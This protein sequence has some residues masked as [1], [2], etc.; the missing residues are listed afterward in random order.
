MSGFEL[1]TA[2]TTLVPDSP[3]V[4]RQKTQSGYNSTGNSTGYNSGADSGDDLFEGVITTPPAKHYTQSTQL[5]DRTPAAKQFSRHTEVIDLTPIAT[6]A[7]QPTQII[8]RAPAETHFTQ[9]T[10]IIDRTAPLS[11]PGNITSPEVQ[12]PVSSPFRP[13]PISSV[14]NVSYAPK[15]GRLAS[16]MAPAGTSFRAPYSTVDPRPAK[17]LIVIDLSD[18]DGPQYK[19]GSSDDDSPLRGEIKPSNFLPKSKKFSLTGSEANGSSPTGSESSGQSRFHDI[20]TNSKF[21]PIK[22]SAGA[23]LTGSVFDSRNRDPRSTSSH[24]VTPAVKK[25]SDSTSMG[26]GSQRRQQAQSQPERAM[27]VPQ[28]ISLDDEQ[29]YPLRRKMY[30]IQQLNPGAYTVLMI[31]N[32]LLKCKGSVDDAEALLMK[33]AQRAIEISDDENGNGSKGQQTHL[34]PQMKR[35]LEVPVKSIRERY[36]STQNPRKVA[37]P[38]V[39]IVTPPKKPRRRLQQG[40]RHP[41]SPASVVESPKPEIIQQVREQSDAD[42]DDSGIGSEPKEDPVL[43]GR[44]LAFINRCKVEDLADLANIKI[45]MAAKMIAQRPFKNFNAAREVTDGSITKAGKK[46]SKAPIGEKI[47]QT[48][49]DMW[50]GYEAVDALVAKCEQLGKPLAEEISKWGF[51]VFGAAKTGELE[52]VSFDDDSDSQRDSGIGTPSS[53]AASTNGEAGEDDIKT[54]TLPRH[55]RQNKFLKQPAIMSDEITLKDY[56][57]V[58]L[59]WLALL[60][61]HKL[62]C[63]LADDMG[64]GKTCQ[65]IAFLSHLAEIG[66][67]GPHLVIVP[68]STLENWLREFQF[69]CPNLIVEPYYGM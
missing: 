16:V 32:A 56:Q 52:M 57:L 50:S 61:K 25:V 62:S 44:V 54:A 66:V 3:A 8:D 27:P 43:E 26:Y 11:S 34:N 6:R 58:G 18:D 63:I 51:D 17:K 14:N 48:A 31:R 37:Q 19:G 65:V 20:M 1:K 55:G 13:K 68:P 30:R 53:K 45:D 12:I 24:I 35:Q 22:K 28:D 7:T 39:P 38:V 36:S 60:Y 40:R 67:S 2:N 49:V 69:F 9:P 41:S 4:K 33:P 42:S 29:D 5:I 64:L 10:Q 59:N 21:D 46:S 15:A 47:I 23:S